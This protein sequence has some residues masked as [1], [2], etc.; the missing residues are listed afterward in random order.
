MP[1]HF[2][3]VRKTISNNN[4]IKKTMKKL[5]TVLL[6]LMLFTA[7]FVFTSCNEP[8]DDEY[9]AMLVEGGWDGTMDIS[10]TKND[11]KYPS[12]GTH[13]QFWN[14]SNSTT[15][16]YGKWCNKFGNTAPIQN[17]TYDFTWEAK[18]KVIYLHFKTDN[19][20]YAD[21]SNLKI[22][23]YY[24]NSL[25]FT[26]KI[27]TMDDS[28]SADFELIHTS[29]PWD[30]SYYVIYPW[31]IYPFYPWYDPWFDPFYY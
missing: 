7:P 11:V 20:E 31:D 27:S 25:K 15:S 17:L 19:S 5:S 13:V 10:Y 3:I 29:A 1:L 24:I 9:L 28:K 6:L 23:T 26:G 4:Q 16:G 8:T 12:T 30:W 2:K 22:G 21:K 14:Y 18:D